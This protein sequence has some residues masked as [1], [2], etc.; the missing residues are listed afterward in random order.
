MQRRDVVSSPSRG[1][2]RVIYKA[3]ICG[4]S[5]SYRNPIIKRLMIRCGLVRNIFNRKSNLRKE[6]S[7]LFKSKVFVFLFV[8]IRNYLYFCGLFNREC[9]YMYSGYKCLADNMILI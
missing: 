2:F 8:L 4:I 3:K 7:L 1:N 9:L 6:D 5:S